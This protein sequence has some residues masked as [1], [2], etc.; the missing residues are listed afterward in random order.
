MPRDRTAAALALVLLALFTPSAGSARASADVP[1]AASPDAAAGDGDDAAAQAQAGDE[2]D[3]LVPELRF[4]VEAKTHWRS[5]DAARFAS[6]F[7]FAAED[8]PPGASNAFLAVADPGEHFELS[9]V[10]LRVDAVWGEGLQAHAKVDVIDLYDR[11]PT[12]GDKKLDVDEAWVRFG[13]EPEPAE[14]PERTG[15]YLKV[16]KFGKFERQDDRHLESYGLIST[17][18]N[19]FEDAGAELGV[20]FGRFV[21]L[22]A[23]ATQGN[24]VFMRD[25]NALAGDNGTEELLRERPRNVPRLGTGLPILYDAEVEDLS[26]DGAEELGAGVGVRFADASGARAVDVLVWGY[27]RELADTVRLE[28]TFYGGDLDLLDGPLPGTGL[29]IRGNEK[30]ELGANLWLYLD[31]LSFFGQYVDQEIAGLVRKG[32][33]GE[34]AW[35]LDLP[36]FASVGGRQL[37]PWI[38]PAV[39]YSHFEPEFFGGSPQFPAISLRWEWDKL[40]W[41]VRVGVVQGID[42]TIENADNTFVVRGADRS[43]DE[44]LATLR[45]RM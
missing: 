32:W 3:S 31:G 13:R 1:S 18:F 42:L 21:Y 41:G 5:S 25:P 23:S 33:E 45:W 2:S 6:P 26:V 14:L 12:S 27:E 34:V 11:N 24:P 8:L 35:R 22:K 37:F 44:I 40:D 28:G 15:A 7:P 19:R 39:R 17:A 38:A 30:R 4:G 36:V 29:P 9:T 10:T 20:H 43:A 16:G